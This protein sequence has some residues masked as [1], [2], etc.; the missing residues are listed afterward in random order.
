MTI[1]EQFKDL[2]RQFQAASLSYHG[3]VEPMIASALLGIGDKKRIAVRRYLQDLLD[4]QQDLRTINAVWRES[5]ADFFFA[6]D[7]ELLAFLK[8]VQKLALEVHD[9]RK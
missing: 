3:S 6:N 9:E 1:P 5:P 2:C 8:L 7:E 4:G